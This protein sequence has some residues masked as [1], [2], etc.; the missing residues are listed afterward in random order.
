MR[1]VSVSTGKVMMSIATEKSIA[2]YRSGFDV[3]RFHEMGTR[4]MELENGY[5][6]NEPINYAVR[7]AVEQGVIEM[8][9]DG[10]RK[11][12]WAYKQEED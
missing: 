8:I 6:V 10:V 3:F 5:S 11:G 12:L 9:D 2:S 4:L 7:A 1:L